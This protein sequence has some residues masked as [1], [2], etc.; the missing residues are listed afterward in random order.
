M[1]VCI[2]HKVD[3]EIP[4]KVRRNEGRGFVH[5]R[6]R[7]MT[8]KQDTTND[9]LEQAG[10]DGEIR[11]NTVAETVNKLLAYRTSGTQKK[12]PLEPATICSANN[13]TVAT[14]RDFYER[15]ISTISRKN[16][17]SSSPT[18]SGDDGSS[19]SREVSPYSLRPK[20]KLQTPGYSSPLT[21]PP[22]C[23]VTLSNDEKENRLPEFMQ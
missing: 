22:A 8:Q 7:E 13:S 23:Q 9:K 1:F 11:K 19:S 18:L 21:R 15:K 4:G 12:L 6:L 3:Q 14:K 17:T 5:Q 2:T 20:T 10:P 16:S